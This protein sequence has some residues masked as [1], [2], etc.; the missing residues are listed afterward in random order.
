[1][2]EVTLFN[3]SL[4]FTVSNALFYVSTWRLVNSMDAI[5]KK[6]ITDLERIRGGSSVECPACGDSFMVNCECAITDH[7]LQ[8]GECL[9]SGESQGSLQRCQTCDGSGA[10]PWCDGVG[11][12]PCYDCCVKGA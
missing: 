2:N 9:G 11:T 3:L 10:C 12:V 7:A 4:V 1:M 5:N 8:C 6:F